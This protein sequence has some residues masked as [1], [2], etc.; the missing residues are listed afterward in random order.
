MESR[1][2]AENGRMGEKRDNERNENWHKDE[3]QKRRG[4]WKK[5]VNERNDECRR[6]VEMRRGEENGRRRKIMRMKDTRKT[7]WE[8][9]IYQFE[10]ENRRRSKENQ[11]KKREN[12][13]GVKLL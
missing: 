8:K 7:N 5:H 10:G 4:G 9:Y 2:R 12:P 6:N 13:K 1:I 3:K 11:L